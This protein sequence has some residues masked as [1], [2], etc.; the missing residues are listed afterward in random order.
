MHLEL[1]AFWILVWFAATRRWH[2]RPTGFSIR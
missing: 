2:G 1:I